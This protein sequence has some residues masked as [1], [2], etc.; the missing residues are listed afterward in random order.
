MQ[1]NGPLRSTALE[2]PRECEVGDKP[3]KSELKAMQRGLPP[4]VDYQD[5]HVRP[6]SVEKLKIAEDC[7]RTYLKERRVSK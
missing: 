4:P 1:L 3:K 2:S 6:K 5:Q 7:L